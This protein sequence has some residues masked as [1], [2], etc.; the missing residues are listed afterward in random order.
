M[1]RLVTA[2]SMVHEFRL[3]RN[4]IE[5][6]V[7]APAL[8]LVTSA[9]DRDGAGLTAYGLAESLT[10]THQRTVLVTTD[11]SMAAPLASTSSRPV[12]R[13]RR[14][15]DRL[16]AIDR[17]SPSEGRF[18]VVSISPERL[19]TISHSSVATLVQELRAANDYVVVDASDL[20]KNSFGLL[21]VSSA[22]A[23]LIAFR[24]GRAQQ[25]TDRVMLDT[26]ERAESK[27][28]GVVMTDEATIDR[29]T[30]RDEPVAIQD[31]VLEAKPRLKPAAALI[32]RFELALTRFGK[33]T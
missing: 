9:T 14:E 8:V 28:L 11:T 17:S 6:E 12:E 10:K 26:L 25:P 27:V 5:A 31:P 19:A 2:D 29:F 4:R 22:D 16:E 33:S 20:L 1:K 23:T 24:A 18:S 13:R 30:H 3:L 15:G 21:L 32:E 7:R